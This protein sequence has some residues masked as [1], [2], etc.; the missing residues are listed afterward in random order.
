MIKAIRILPLLFMVFATSGQALGESLPSLEGN[1][2]QRYRACLNMAVVNPEQAFGQAIGWEGL[3]GGHPA[4][5]CALAAL[6]GLGQYGEA[7]QGFEALADVVAGGI[8]FKARLLIRAAEAWLLYNNLDLAMDAVDTS[9]RMSPN[10][11]EA[12]VIRA[13][14]MAAKGA[15][16]EATDDLNTAIA[17]DPSDADA[18]AFRASA[19][20]ALEALDLAREDATRALKISPTHP[21][22]LLELG[23]VMRI[24]GKPGEARKNWL[25]VITAWPA[26]EAARAARAN[27]ELLDVS[28]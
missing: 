25:A 20:R 17:I 2:E 18:L 27:I 19:W 24:L 1:P 7:A 22:A 4:R 26:S 15:Y 16:W 3:G 6:M 11:P 21:A 8:G 10:K 14:I 28:R 9:I 12:L 23:N 13:R 5:Y